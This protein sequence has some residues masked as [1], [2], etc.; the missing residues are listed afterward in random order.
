[1]P[2][3]REELLNVATQAGSL[4][5]CSGAEIYR[6]EESMDTDFRSVWRPGQQH[7]CHPKLH[8]CHHQHARRCSH[9]PRQTDFEP[10]DKSGSR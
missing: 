6:V 5:L 7:L 10:A 4:L 9:Y 1:M 8:L 3:E 2:V